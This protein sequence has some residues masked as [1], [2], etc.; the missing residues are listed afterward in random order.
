M[1]WLRIEQAGRFRLR[2]R[3]SRP[4]RSPP[5]AAQYKGGLFWLIADRSP[6]SSVGSGRSSLSLIWGLTPTGHPKIG[7]VKI[8]HLTIH[9]R[10]SIVLTRMWSV[11]HFI[12]LPFQVPHGRFRSFC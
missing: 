8:N 7:Q 5:H 9:V 11:Q 12:T 6:A 10:T 1:R 3:C 4:F 2:R